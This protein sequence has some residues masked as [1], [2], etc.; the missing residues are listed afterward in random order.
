MAWRED[1]NDMS[2]A[3]VLSSL[4][5]CLVVS[6]S[7]CL[8]VVVITSGARVTSS[9]VPENSGYR[10]DCKLPHAQHLLYSTVLYCCRNLPQYNA[11][12]AKLLPSHP[13]HVCAL[14]RHRLPYL[15]SA[16]LC[17]QSALPAAKVQ[18]QEHGKQQNSKQ[19]SKQHDTPNMAVAQ[20]LGL[21]VGSYCA[22]A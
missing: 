13:L 16:G 5:R 19:N 12:L 22:A 7:L 14:R 1:W 3:Q 18:Q 15:Q 20:S 21:V 4:S 6:L 11:E 8:V 9:R 2:L 17:L 10:D